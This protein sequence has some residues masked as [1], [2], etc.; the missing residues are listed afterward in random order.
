MKKQVRFVKQIDPIS[1]D[2]ALTVGNVYEVEAF[3][4]DTTIDDG[5]CIYDDVGDPSF[6]NAGEWEWVV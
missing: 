6:L 5:I 3:C 4:N 1:V 2:D